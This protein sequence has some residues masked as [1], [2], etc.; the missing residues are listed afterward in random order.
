MP[1]DDNDGLG[2]WREALRGRAPVL[3]PDEIRQGFYRLRQKNGAWEPIRF[4]IED[5]YWVCLR[6]DVP[7]PTSKIAQLFQWAC[8]QPVEQ[9]AYFDAV[10]GMGW[11]DEPPA[12]IG[13]NLPPEADPLDRLQIEFLGE[14][15][16]VD[17]MLA[18]AVGNQ[19][20]ADRLAIWAD[21]IQKIHKSVE[22][23]KAV[24]KRPALD[25]VARIDRRWGPLLDTTEAYYKKAKSH[26]SPWLAE[27]DRI[28]TERQETATRNA[29]MLRAK[30]R[31]MELAASQE[32]AGLK[33]RLEASIVLEEALA[34]ESEAV[35][36]NPSAGRT[37]AKVSLKKKMSALVF[38]YDIALQAMKDEPDIRSEVQRIA[39]AYAKSKLR[40]P[41]PAGTRRVESRVPV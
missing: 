25:E 2:Y 34:A 17:E 32:G 36:R 16:Q 21:R 41:M 29:A 1:L 39:N 30:A 18:K 11:Q 19:A 8:R 35:R 38:D 24:E 15:E 28:E 7:Q 33:Q 6:N 40:P 9:R 27:L 12:P 14:K 37:N 20:E 5:D 13:H 10:A 3:A 23:E 4:M 26:L 22:E 31:E